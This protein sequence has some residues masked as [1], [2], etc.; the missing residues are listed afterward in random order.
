[1]LVMAASVRA[2]RTACASSL[3]AYVEH[4]HVVVELGCGQF[5]ISV[6]PALHQVQCSLHALR[7]F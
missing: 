7:A 5:Y 4:C 3:H 2:G 1:M 6:L